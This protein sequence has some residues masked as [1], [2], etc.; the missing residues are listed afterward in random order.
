MLWTSVWCGNIL[1]ENKGHD[2]INQLFLV[3]WIQ[4]DGDVE[5]RIRQ[6]LIIQ[7]PRRNEAEK[8]KK[9]ASF[10]YFKVG[11]KLQNNAMSGCTF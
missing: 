5:S 3:K 8:T 10:E 1:F 7:N 2:E 4:L 6:D 9:K 11:H